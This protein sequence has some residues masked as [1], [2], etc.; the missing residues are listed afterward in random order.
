MVNGYHRNDLFMII[1]SIEKSIITYFVPPCFGFVV[2]EL[3]YVLAKIRVLSLLRVDIGGK[4]SFYSFLPT[5][6]VLLKVF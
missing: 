3:F 6:E 2:R 5:A 1:D 4:F